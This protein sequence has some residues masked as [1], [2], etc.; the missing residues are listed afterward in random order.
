MMYRL[1]IDKNFTEFIIKYYP[2]LYEDV[3]PIWYRTNIQLLKS[4][5]ISSSCD[6]K[7]YRELVRNI[8][9]KMI[10]ILKE[11]KLISLQEK[12]IAISAFLS[13]NMTRNIIRVLLDLQKHYDVNLR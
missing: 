13:I 5:F 12:L 8:S 4:M 11:N 6:L 10:Y 9:N 2:D 1:E 3:K 7:I